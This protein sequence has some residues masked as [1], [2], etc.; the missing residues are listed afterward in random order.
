MIHRITMTPAVPS[1]VPRYGRIT[2]V[3]AFVATALLSTA[4]LSTA[5]IAPATAAA[6]P[7]LSVTTASVLTLPGDDG[8]NDDAVVQIRSNSPLSVRVSVVSRT[9][10]KVVRTIMA[11]LNLRKNGSQYRGSTRVSADGLATGKYYVRATDRTN[12]SVTRNAAV[13]IGSGKATK[14]TLDTTERMLFPL[15]DDYR[16]TL[17]TEIAATDETGIVLPVTGTLTVTS[18]S[19]N[20]SAKVSSSSD[21]IARTRIDVS[22][23]PAGKARV[24][25]SVAGPAGKAKKSAT[26]AL[27][28]AGTRIKTLTITPSTS[29]VYPV[30]DNFRDSISIAVTSTVS[31][32]HAVPVA[33]T[34]TITRKGERV[35]SWKLTS[36]TKKTVTWNGRNNSRIVPGNYTIRAV[37]KGP[38]GPVISRSGTLTVSKKQLHRDQVSVWKTAKSVL[39]HTTA[40]DAKRAGTCVASGPRLN[41]TG[42]DATYDNSLSLYTWGSVNVPDAVRDSSRFHTPSLRVTADVSALH[43]SGSWAYVSKSR[44]GTLVKG[45]RALSWLPLNGN[46]SS[47][48]ISV[49]LK[50]QTEATIDRFR[51]QY[52]YTTLR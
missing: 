50:K 39:D 7:T 9:T 8:F 47:T 36:S 48:T 17:H 29:I 12:A 10:G 1:P 46:P 15:A 13:T 41:C 31:I 25:A 3:L 40:Y 11:S 43:G 38:E 5:S 23:L 21:E 42:Y 34:L 19:K 52:N 16:D 33:G 26:V 20:R 49:S 4:L 28:L 22:G 45:V 44:S 35:A 27:A 2:A 37:M 32:P 14:V 24:R 30:R 51:L 6:K 18:G